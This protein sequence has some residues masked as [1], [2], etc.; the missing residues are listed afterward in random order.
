MKG[1]VA[2]TMALILWMEKRK[3][4]SLAKDIFISASKGLTTLYI[5]AMVLVEI[6]YLSEKN[7]YNW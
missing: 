1:Y 7:R 3:M 4:P 6:G 5:P 2:D